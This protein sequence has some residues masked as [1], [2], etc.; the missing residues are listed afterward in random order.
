MANVYIP[1]EHLIWIS[2]KPGM[3][4]IKRE[5]RLI[6]SEDFK[7]EL[8]EN[9]QMSKEMTAAEAIGWMVINQHQSLIDNTGG[10]VKFSDSNGFQF[11]NISGQWIEVGGSTIKCL[12]PFKLPEPDKKPEV[13]LVEKSTEFSGYSWT[14]NKKEYHP[15]ERAAI[16]AALEYLKGKK[17][18]IK[19]PYGEYE[20]TV[21]NPAD[22]FDCADALQNRWAIEVQP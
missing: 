9:G 8:Q 3:G 11:Q 2:D 15:T 16:D 20:L 10:A 1:G 12:G 14:F 18:V 19:T 4:E 13:V 17:A 22:A 6:V 21:L 5:Y 7:A